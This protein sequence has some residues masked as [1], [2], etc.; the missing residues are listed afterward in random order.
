[1][2][3]FACIIG[4]LL[5][6]SA[7]GQEKFLDIPNDIT[8]GRR[9]VK[10]A[11]SVVDEITGNFAVFI[12]DDKTMNGYLYG[13]DLQLI[14]KYASEGLPKKY[15][16]II[17]R[18]IS[19]NQIRLFLK[20][21]NNKKFGSIL[22]D[23]NTSNSTE[24]EFDFKLRKEKFVQTYSYGDA[25]YIMSIVKDSSL[26]NFYIFKPD[27]GFSKE[28]LDLSKEKFR[29]ATNKP[30]FLYELLTENTT[31][32]DIIPVAKIDEST[33]NAIETTS[34]SSKLYIRENGLVFTLDENL[35]VTY[36]IEISLP[37]LNY[38]LTTVE[39]TPL[40]KLFKT[41]KSN[42]FLFEDN[43]FQIKASHKE[44]IFE[45]K[46]LSSQKEL[47]KIHL[48][49]EDSIYFKNSP[50]IKHGE[51]QDRELKNTSRFL[52][53]ISNTDL[54]IVVLPIQNGYRITMGGK[55]IREY[56]TNEGVSA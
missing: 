17:G 16:E 22:F 20:T 9:Q 41:T 32:K 14:A 10:N 15:D 5:T 19:G 21:S 30:S 52:L 7:L 38:T 1:M 28:T 33:P 49:R 43:I 55:Y 4:V 29:D 39:K 36:I 3:H 46:E 23:F 48:L 37:D 50:I 40:N 54:G 2:K 42:S 44:M 13:K 25:F 45:V 31:F 34:A 27:G 26:L 12:D 8:E 47:K 6:F 18:T 11:F 53:S 24:T 35:N 56:Y 51:F